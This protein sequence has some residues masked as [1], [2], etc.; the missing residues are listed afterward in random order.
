MIFST[1]QLDTASPKR[2]GLR[3][4]CRPVGQIIDNGKNMNQAAIKLTVAII[5]CISTYY[6]SVKSNPGYGSII[7]L[8][9]LFIAVNFYFY[10]H[11]KRGET[12]T[13]ITKA[14]IL[15]PLLIY[16]ILLIGIFSNII[17]W[18]IA[19]NYLQ[20]N[21]NLTHK[22]YLL[23]IDLISIFFSMLILTPTLI[24]IYRDKFTAIIILFTIIIVAYPQFYLNKINLL[25][26]V[27][28]VSAH[29]LG[30]LLAIY[31]ARMIIQRKGY[32][33]AR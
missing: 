5:W 30:G 7:V 12:I 9:I 22:I 26:L 8:S 16:A 32:V 24:Y 2:L 21:S 1:R 28:V 3:V 19:M 17:P 29:M 33:I 10:K 18:P 6:F 27:G 11:W 13:I 31:L 4:N 25:P 23:S 15:I 14:V 20:H